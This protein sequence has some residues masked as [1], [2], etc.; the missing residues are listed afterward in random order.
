MTDEVRA[1]EALK[2]WRYQTA[3]VLESR[4]TKAGDELAS[5][6]EALVVSDT[7]PVDDNVAR[8]VWDAAHD[9]R[10]GYSWETACEIARTEPERR[11]VI[12]KVADA[13]RIAAAAL[14]AKTTEEKANA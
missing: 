4:L 13:R 2:E 5:I 9:G 3:C 14:R 12:G 8:V 6:I 11:D 10:M 1:Q 7:E